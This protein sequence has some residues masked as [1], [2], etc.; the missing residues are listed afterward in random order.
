LSVPTTTGMRAGMWTDLEEG[1]LAESARR[2]AA[3]TRWA[4]R[5]II[6]KSQ[7]AGT[8]R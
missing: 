2:M 6:G 4:C 8:M 7:V 3:I 5:V 1:N